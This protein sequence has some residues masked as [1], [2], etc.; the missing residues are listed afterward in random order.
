[1]SVKNDFEEFQTL[2]TTQISEFIYKNYFNVSCEVFSFD[3]CL[4]IVDVSRIYDEF[5]FL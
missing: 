1:M 2:Y 4:I 3:I 5:I